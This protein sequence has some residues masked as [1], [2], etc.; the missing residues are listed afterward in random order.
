MTVITP[1]SGD[2]VVVKPLTAELRESLVS[3]YMAQKQH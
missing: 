3:H 2:K 1:K